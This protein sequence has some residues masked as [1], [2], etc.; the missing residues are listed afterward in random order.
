[1]SRGLRE[2]DPSR[3]RCSRAPLRV[4]AALVVVLLWSGVAAQPAPAPWRG[5]FDAV[6]ARTQDAM[7][8]TTE[9]LQ[10]LVARCDALK[11]VIDGLDES[12]RKVYGRRLKG[13]RDL[14][15]FVLDFRRKGGA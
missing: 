10:S 2:L 4:A 1:V 12:L 8:L 3:G 14:Y 15:Q 13:C 6:C 11:P 7:A 5:E 9:E